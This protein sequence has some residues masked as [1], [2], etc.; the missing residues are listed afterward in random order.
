VLVELG[1][2]AE[3][4]KQLHE[5]MRQLHDPVSKACSACAL[6]VGEIRAGDVDLAR[7]CQDMAR[8]LDTRWPALARAEREVARAAGPC[9]SPGLPWT[10]ASGA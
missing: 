3:G 4:V 6:V 1:R 10:A 2:V 7:D 9:A 5:T 8:L